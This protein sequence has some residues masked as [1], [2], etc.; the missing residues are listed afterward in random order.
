MSDALDRILK[1]IT[2]LR[3]AAR[4]GAGA[5]A[6]AAAREAWRVKYLG[7]KSEFQNIGRDIGA[8]AAEEREA[9]GKAFNQLKNDLSALKEKLDGGAATRN[10]SP[11]GQ[12]RA[13][14]AAADYTL[15]GVAPYVGALH[16]LTATY[17]EVAAFF[18]A[19]GFGVAYGPEVEDDFHNFGALNFPPEHPSRDAQDTIYV[20]DERLLRTHTSPV[21]I[22]VMMSQPPPLRVIVPGRCFRAD[23]PDASHFPV[24]T[25][26]EGLLVDRN[27]SLGDLK[28]TLAAFA[29][30]VFGPETKMLFVPH[31]F[32][33]T[34]PSA[35]VHISC[36]VCRGAGCGTCG[37]TGWLEIAGAGMV[38]PNVFRNVG[39]DPEEWVGYAF[40]MGLER[41]AMLV[42]GINDIR[43]FYEND[44][45]FTRQFG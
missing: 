45:R 30:Y 1:E 24:F 23:A 33:F 22:R 39:Y 18:A 29:R 12:N 19:L 41:I 11:R 36:T 5:A 38:H 28:G 44:L 27:V 42:Y 35:E 14:E 15:P 2:A 8:L 25:Q 37:R 21:Q 3:E 16:P 10:G 34:E 31:Y 40:G 32:P 9:A 4:A 6:D 43:L 20:N 7:R 26:V 17:Y 13:D